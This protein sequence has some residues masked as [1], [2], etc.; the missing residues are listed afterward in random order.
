M[1][2]IAYRFIANYCTMWIGKN[3][4]NEKNPKNILHFI[5]NFD[6]R[7][8]PYNLERAENTM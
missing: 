2:L 1:E 5:F 6:K 3:F 7:Y 8:V 4:A